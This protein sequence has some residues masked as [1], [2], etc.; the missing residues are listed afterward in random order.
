MKKKKKKKTHL[1]G[2]LN[3][4]FLVV[5]LLFSTL[6]LRLGIVQ[7]VN[8]KTYEKQV[9]KTEDKTIDNPVPRGEIFDR[10]NRVMVDNQ[11]LNAITYTRYS[12]TTQED[13][14]RVA[15]KLAQYIDKDTSKVTERDQKD[16]WL[17]TR[18]KQAKQKITKKEWALFSDSKLTDKQIYDKQLERITEKDL[19]SISKQELEVIAIKREM[20]SGY[21][22]TTQ[23]IKNEGVTP[24]EY[25]L[26]SEHL[27]ELPGIDTTT[28]WDRDYVFND[29]L[30]TLFGNISSTNEGIPLDSLD[31]YLSKG[32]S[33]NEQ[34]GTSYIEKQYESILR[35]EKSQTKDIEDR[36]GN[37]VDQVTIDKGQRGKD[38]SLTIDVAL[39]TAVEQSIEKELRKTKAKPTTQYLDRAFIVMMD[40]RT[41]EVLT[42]AGKRLVKNP[43]TGQMEMKDFALGNM[44]SAYAM[45]SAVKGATVLAGLDSGAITPSTLLVDAP[46][47]FK[48]TKE[49]KSTHNMGAI[50]LQRALKESSNVFMFKT[51]MRMAGA[52]Y[53]YNG[54]LNIRPS[55]FEE[56]RQYYSQ[57][58]LGVKTGIDLPQ[59][60]TGYKGKSHTPGLALDFAIG[61]YDTYTPLEMA[62][63]ISTIANGGYRMK[64]QIVKEIREPTINTNEPSNV[65]YHAEPTILNR[66]TMKESYIKQV[67]EGMKKVYQEPHGTAYNY[68]RGVSYDPAGKT[69]TAQAFYNGKPTYNSTLVGF[70]PYN[71]PEVAFAVVVPNAYTTSPNGISREIGRDAL[72][73]YFKLKDQGEKEL[74]EQGQANQNSVKTSSKSIESEVS[75]IQ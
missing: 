29:T 52:E 21:T 75:K 49:K 62:Q 7:I 67:Q 23:T 30:R 2:R 34:V 4:L 26:V 45:G 14:L 55:I 39:Q 73:A 46:I 9:E 24:K 41:G 53:K 16:Y 70:A 48:G 72:D 10:Y 22:Q 15:R 69:G 60:M 65:L 11:P 66:I 33:R 61:Q 47:K 54:S 58:G 12:N 32:Y 25:A 57:F 37:I 71:N 19:Q 18:P 59:E 5:F 42:M 20:D 28:Y 6:I 13:R 74:E 35:G 50:N 43:D 31:Y 64:P 68:F 36:A 44:T 56:M 1:T 8:G 51:I 17:Q 38:I 63:Y 40:P 3:V 27:A